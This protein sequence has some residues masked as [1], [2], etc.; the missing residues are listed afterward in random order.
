M[1]Y[2]GDKQKKYYNDLSTGLIKIDGDPTGLITDNG[3]GTFNVNRAGKYRVVD[4]SDPN[5]FDSR[6]RIYNWPITSNID[7]TVAGSDGNIIV[8][9]DKDQTIKVTML[10]S[11]GALLDA[12]SDPNINDVVQI[13]NIVVQGGVVFGIEIFL[14]V[15]NNIQNKFRNLLSYMP[16]LRSILQP[17]ILEP[18]GGNLQ[19]I[20]TSGF[21]LIPIVGFEDSEGRNPDQS[22]TTSSNPVNIGIVTRDNVLQSFS[23]NLDVNNYESSP[24]VITAKAN[25]KATNNFALG[26]GPFVVQLYGQEEY[27]GTSPEIQASTANEDVDNPG[28]SRFGSKL[29]QYSVL[30]GEVDLLAVT[31]IIK[32][33]SRFD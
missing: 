5:N 22:E 32:D 20:Y 33:L 25:N 24:G 9:V 21:S 17:P 7:H 30:Q 27:A 18:V 23:T 3:D 2:G 26:F 14:F 28:I 12:I 11:G 15:N 19:L 16:T 31:T 4:R 6:S 13:G 29:K 10:S 1:G 8:Y